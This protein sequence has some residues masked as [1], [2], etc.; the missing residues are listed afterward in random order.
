[1]PK[2]QPDFV[3]PVLRMVL[4]TEESMIS[5]GWEPGV[6][7]SILGAPKQQSHRVLE[8]KLEGMS[9]MGFVEAK[10]EGW[11]NVAG[12]DLSRDIRWLNVAITEEDV[13]REFADSEV[14]QEFDWW[15]AGE[16]PASRL[17]D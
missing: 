3:G 5:D 8:L 2:I 15:T 11:H 1:M 7:T 16:G 17:I 13:T 14:A 12:V 4:V 9:G 10:M 6:G